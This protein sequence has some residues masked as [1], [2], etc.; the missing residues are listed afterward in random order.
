MR[1]KCAAAA[2]Y[3]SID[4]DDGRWDSSTVLRRPSSRYRLAWL[5]R[6]NR[7]LGE[8]S[9]LRS[10]R[11]FARAFR[12]RMTPTLA[13][14]Q[15]TRWETGQILADYRTVSRYETLLGLP[16]AFISTAFESAR[17]Y[18]DGPSTP[19][20][21][22]RLSGD[23]TRSL[24]ELIDFALTPHAMSGLRWRRLTSLTHA[25]P[26][27]VLHPPRLWE[28]IAGNLLEE[29]VVAERQAWFPRQ[30]AM[31]KLLEHPAS[32]VCAVDACIALARDRGNPVFIEPISLLEASPL[33]PANNYVLLQVCDPDNEQALLGALLAATSKVRQGH[34]GPRELTAMTATAVR[35]IDRYAGHPTLGALT[36][37]LGVAIADRANGDQTS[38][39]LIALKRLPHPKHIVDPAMSSLCHQLASATQ[40]HLS[41]T[42]TGLDSTLVELI[43][44]ALFSPNP[45]ERLYAA[46]LIGATPYRQPLAEAL[47]AAISRTGSLR[48][49]LTFER[50]LQL[51]ARLG[52]SHH[53]T[54][55]RTLLQDPTLPA[56]ARHAAAWASTHSI[57]RLPEST[58][59]V[60][61]D[62]QLSLSRTRPSTLDEDILRGV[63]YSIGTDAHRPLL[64]ELTADHL[65]PRRVRDL[66][67]WW[68]SRTGALVDR[69]P[70]SDT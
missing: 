49:N 46:A 67:N 56:R 39:D 19:A 18:R 59:R 22:S 43:R 1:S 12:E 61:L 27:L 41:A 51:M 3:R 58:W 29:L 62:Q 2:P 60:I 54:F 47:T 50:G 70:V 9:E 44:E 55:V 6:T 21:H 15:I 68:A 66:A 48:T 36:V 32:G 24:H 65:L 45:D 35:L 40:A 11:Q 53:R 63:V 23:D 5:L 57:G 34:F 42:S 64:E 16:E 25:R 13:P 30:E 28:T 8:N 33:P 69:S 17:R 14:S 52:V 31:S 26:D 7:R 10:A 20:P 37:E 38:Q 4:G